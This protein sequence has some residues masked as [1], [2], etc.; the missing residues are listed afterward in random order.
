[1]SSSS[2]AHDARLAIT[3]KKQSVRGGWERRNGSTKKVRKGAIGRT[4]SRF[5]F[6]ALSDRE[7]DR[8]DRRLVAFTKPENVEQSSSGFWQFV[9]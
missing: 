6:V 2:N 1:M 9:V 8:V 4:V 3:M 5:E 7:P